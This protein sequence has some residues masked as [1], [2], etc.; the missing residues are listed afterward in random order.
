[1]KEFLQAMF[2]STEDRIKNPFIGA[3]LTSWILFNW[4]PILYIIFS[5]E[6]IKD[7]I[8]YIT[9][10]D[11]YNDQYNYFWLP[12]ISAIFYILIL[13]YL[14]F[15]FE[16]L[17]K[18]S[19]KWRNKVSL[20]TKDEALELE[21]GIAKNE[22]TL[23][24]KRTEFRERNS[25]NQMVENLNSQILQLQNSLNDSRNKNSELSI[26]LQDQRNG[27]EKQLTETSKTLTDHILKISS[28][29]SAEKANNFDLTETINE[30]NDKYLQTMRQ[31]N[32]LERQFGV[33]KF[34]INRLQNPVNKI[35]QFQNERI[36]E[37]FNTI[38]QIRYFHLDEN[39]TI[40]Q[41]VIMEKINAFSYEEDESENNVRL[42]LNEY[43]KYLER[44]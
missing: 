30:I 38:N 43:Q 13:P 6:K 36:L 11:S 32:L 22:I 10:T 3:F 21:I 8:Y 29:L 5:D 42:A 16:Y 28:D 39:I 24:E 18:F 17:V 26:Q 19:N 31:L 12:L 7:K 9:E 35:L 4:K 33:A 14:S 20:E 2:K 41:E 34:L 25:H 44:I 27:L 15:S 37:Y 1:M 23:E 40:D